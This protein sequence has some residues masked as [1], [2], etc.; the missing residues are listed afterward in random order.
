MAFDPT[1]EV[2][3]PQDLTYSDLLPSSVTGVPYDVVVAINPNDTSKK[4]FARGYLRGYHHPKRWGKWY[5]FQW[6]ST[7]GNWRHYGMTAGNY[8]KYWVYPKYCGTQQHY[9]VPYAAASLKDGVTATGWVCNFGGR[10]DMGWTN[11][12]TPAFRYDTG[13]PD[14]PDGEVGVWR[15]SNWA[16]TYDYDCLPF[17]QS[18]FTADVFVPYVRDTLAVGTTATGYAFTSRLGIFPPADAWRQ[19]TLA[20]IGVTYKCTQVSPVHIWEKV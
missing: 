19:G 11:N 5:D 20:S 1:G 3:L 13:L 8:Q 6:D 10:A 18:G 2:G 16:K 14:M 12:L 7:L 9:I 17:A 4:Y 15:F